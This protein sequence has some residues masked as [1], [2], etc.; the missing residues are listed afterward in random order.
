MSQRPHE[1]FSE[2]AGRVQ[3]DIIE[4][5]P[6]RHLC[7]CVISPTEQN[8]NAVSHCDGANDSA[9]NVTVFL[10]HGVA[11]AVE[12][13]RYQLDSLLAKNAVNRIVAIDLIGHGRSSAPR[14]QEAYQFEAIALDVA[15][16]FTQYR[17]NN[18]MIIGHSYGYLRSYLLFC[19]NITVCSWCATFY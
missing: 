1:L 5:R 10:I 7:V 18:N 11:G 16:L 14:H 13:W 6:Q 9:S 2:L 3:T 19:Y 8:L 15:A 4:L 17:S 12:V